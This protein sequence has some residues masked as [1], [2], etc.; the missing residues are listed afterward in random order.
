VVDTPGVRQFQLWDV[1][2]AEVAGYYRDLRPFVSRCRFPD[3]THTHEADCAVT[4]CVYGAT[5]PCYD[6]PDGTQDVG[7]CR[8]GLA[9]CG[10]DGFGEA[11]APSNRTAAADA[12]TTV[13][14][15]F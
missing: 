8:Q 6:G 14:A 13:T 5:R 15:S 12:I 9:S 7:L 3:C 11:R 1:I 2:P 4:P 10:M